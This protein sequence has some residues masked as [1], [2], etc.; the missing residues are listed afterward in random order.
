MDEDFTLEWKLSFT[1]LSDRFDSDR[2]TCSKTFIFRWIIGL[3]EYTVMDEF[4]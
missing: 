1:A 4:L 3:E 2:P